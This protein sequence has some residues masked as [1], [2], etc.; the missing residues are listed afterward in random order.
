M[1][2][3]P[4]K[5]E[6]WKPADKAAEAEADNPAEFEP[7]HPAAETSRGPVPNGRPK[8]HGEQDEPPSKP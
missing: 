2:A 4:P 7:S 1:R 3:D 6:S 5:H 8:T